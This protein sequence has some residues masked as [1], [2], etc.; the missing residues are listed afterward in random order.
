[1]YIYGIYICV[2]YIYIYRYIY[3]YACM[4][5]SDMDDTVLVTNAW[6]CVGDGATSA[7]GAMV[8]LKKNLKMLPQTSNNKT[9]I[10][11]NDFCISHIMV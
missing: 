11:S 5:R 1:M 9:D 10:S 8:E 7:T 6:Y 3:I 2:G 4:F